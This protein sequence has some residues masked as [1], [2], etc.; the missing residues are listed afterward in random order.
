MKS[1]ETIKRFRIYPP[2][3]YS[4]LERW[5]K[6]MSCQGWHL[7]SRKFCVIYYFEK[8][9]QEEKEYFVW[10]PT[11]TGEGKYSISLR[12]PDL[13]K[14]YGVPKKKSLLNKYAVE[15]YDT[16]VEVN[17]EKID[18]ENDIGYKELKYDRDRLYRLRFFRN[19]GLF[20]IVLISM[21]LIIFLR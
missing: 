5:L 1:K 3:L 4:K 19:L 2:F 9:K 8:G 6:R 10:D 7:V 15:K 11:Y 17:T 18:I 12:Y 13:I 16:I 21:F 20:A 14:T